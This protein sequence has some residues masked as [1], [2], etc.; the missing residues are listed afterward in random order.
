M[1]VIAVSKPLRAVIETGETDARLVPANSFQATVS[2]EPFQEAYTVV[3]PFAA[4]TAAA[5]G[6]LSGSPTHG[7]LTAR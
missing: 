6:A 7:E 2:V 5:A 3:C 4:V 1:V